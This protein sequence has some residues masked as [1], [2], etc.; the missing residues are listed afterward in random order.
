MRTTLT[1]LLGS[2]ARQRLLCS[3]CGLVLLF[4]VSFTISAQESSLATKQLEDV[5]LRG[6]SVGSLL[7][8]VALQYDIPI[9]FECAMN[10]SSPRQTRLEFDKI[11]VA[12]L[13]DRLLAEH[14]DYSWEISE[15]VIHVFPKIGRRDPIVERLLNVK[16]GRFSL[17]KGAVIWTVEGTLLKTSEFKEVVDDYGLGTVGWSFSGFYLPHFGKN[18]AL[19]VS[20]TTVRSILDRIINESPTA[21]FWSISRDSHEHT[22]SIGFDAFPEGT[23]KNF[24][25]IDLEELERLSY[26]I[27]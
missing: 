16:I 10:G 3:L 22:F 7:S 6:D 23:P 5:R 11:R 4:S 24:R 20:D 8:A 12:D 27:P 14:R 9:G 19:D 1:L 21:K 26:P 18:Y 13:L 25:H 17:K 15:G 2:R